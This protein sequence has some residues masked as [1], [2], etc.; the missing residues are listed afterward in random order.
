[1]TPTY[2]DPDNT[3]VL[4]K[5]IIKIQKLVNDLFNFQYAQF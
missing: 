3:S 2:L 1:M 5:D 4:L